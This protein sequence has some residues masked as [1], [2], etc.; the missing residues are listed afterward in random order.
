MR[1]WHK[2]LLAAAALCAL[3]GS[4]ALADKDSDNKSN[5]GTPGPI[6][7]AGLPFLALAG[8][9]ALVRWRRNRNRAE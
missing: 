4:A 8:G 3:A 2:T 6:A 7:G 5:K 1:S 9:Y